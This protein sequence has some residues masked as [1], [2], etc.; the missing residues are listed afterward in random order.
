[1]VGAGPHV[2]QAPTELGVPHQRRQVF[3]DDRHAHVV[4]RCIG[5]DADGMVRGRPATKQPQVAGAGQLDGR[6]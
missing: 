4:D 1:V 5:D 6:V 3:E 2:E